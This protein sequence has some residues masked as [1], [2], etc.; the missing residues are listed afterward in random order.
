MIQIDKGIQMPAR[1]T[2]TEYP[3]AA[4]QVGDSFAVPVG[5]DQN[6]ATV[7]RRLYTAANLYMKRA[8]NGTKYAVRT[9]DGS[10]R[11]WRIA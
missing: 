11:V 4:M 7:A 8:N 3:F 5:E 6:A 2:R 9:M 1:K 10:V